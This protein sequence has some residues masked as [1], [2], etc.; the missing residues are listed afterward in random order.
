MPMSGGFLVGRRESSIELFI[1][2][3]QC[4]GKMPQ[5]GVRTDLVKPK[6]LDVS[7]CVH[8]VTRLVVV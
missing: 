1:V 7:L 2:S 3:C 4:F 6:L 8:L 5:P